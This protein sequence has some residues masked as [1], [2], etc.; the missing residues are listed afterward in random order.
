[1]CISECCSSSG[2][3]FCQWLRI[4]RSCDFYVHALPWFFHY[5]TDG[6]VDS[7]WQW[8]SWPRPCNSLDLWFVLWKYL[9]SPV[10]K[11]PV[12]NVQKATLTPCRKPRN[13]ECPQRCVWM[14][15][16]IAACQCLSSSIMQPTKTT[17]AAMPALKCWTGASGL[18]LSIT[19]ERAAA[20]TPCFPIDV[21]S[22][23]NFLQYICTEMSAWLQ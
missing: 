9:M 21:P 13:D 12:H 14:Y 6:H 15:N 17:C 19:C 16:N 11:D 8:M 1:M 4:K 10:V 3:C 23:F 20:C 22:Q 18:P 7:P 2:D 5:L